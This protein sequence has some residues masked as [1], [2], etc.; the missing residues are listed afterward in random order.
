MKALGIAATGMLAQQ[1]NVDVIANNIA[2]ANTT[3]FKSG[4]AAFQDLMYQSVE[5]EGA[6]TAG[7]GTSRPVGLDVGLGAQVSG[8][9]RLNSQ[10]GLLSTENQLDLAIEGRGHFI[11]NRPDGTQVY[12]RDGSFQLNAE[13]QLVSLTGYEVEPAIVVPELTRQVEISQTGVVMAYVE[14][15][16]NPVQLGQ[17]TIATFVNEAGMQP[18]GDNLMEETTASGEAIQ[19]NPGDE[20]VGVLQQGYLEN[21]NVNTIQEVTSLISAQRAYEMNSKAVETADQMMMTVNQMK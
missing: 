19:S 20:G 2:N 21:S 1:T 14:N 3:G 10:G 9:I 7:D 11:L 15:D 5:R 6:L 12:T 4:R 13:G 17:L 8:V 18:I 16:P